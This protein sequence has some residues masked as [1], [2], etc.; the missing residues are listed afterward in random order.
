MVND[1]YT[2]GRLKTAKR[3][4]RRLRRAVRNKVLLGICTGFANYFGIEPWI[5]RAAVVI[6]LFFI[7]G[8]VI[9]AYLIAYFVLEPGDLPP[10][11][12]PEA[13]TQESDSIGESRR[14]SKRALTPVATTKLDLKTTRRRYDAL[15]I[16][17]RRLEHFVT[18]GRYDIEREFQK[19]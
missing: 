5:V 16:R 12:E 13:D 6:S 19:L 3:P 2:G 15:E 17:L 7:P 4:R 11:S 14:K 10:G 1:E 18:S 8:I 9:P